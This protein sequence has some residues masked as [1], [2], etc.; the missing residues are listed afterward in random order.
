MW[1][2]EK[3]DNHKLILHLTMIDDCYYMQWWG[4]IATYSPFITTS[5]LYTYIKW[6]MHPI[7]GHVFFSE[8]FHIF[9]NWEFP[10][11]DVGRNKGHRWTTARSFPRHCHVLLNWMASAISHWRKKQQ[12]EIRDF[13]WR[14]YPGTLEW[15]PNPCFG[16]LTPIFPHF[17]TILRD[18]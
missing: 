12:C 5:S 15:Y 6:Y 13:I 8:K 17:N 11:L 9:T 18:L 3:G 2:F 14:F 4:M 16:G 10:S 1:P 7:C